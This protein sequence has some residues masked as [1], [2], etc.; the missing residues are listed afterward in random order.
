MRCARRS[1]SESAFP[2]RVVPIPSAGSLRGVP[3]VRPAVLARLGLIAAIGL[4]A[5][6]C[7]P[8][9]GGSE[10]SS[11][12]D[13]TSAPAREE[14]PAFTLPSLEGEHVTLSDFRGKIVIID[15][16]ATWCPPCEFQVPELNAFWA[17]HRDDGDIA[18]FGISVDEGGPEVVRAWV[19]EKGVEYPILLGDSGLA[20]RYGSH[21]LEQACRV[22][23]AADMID[24]YRL[25]KL[26]ELA[27]PPTPP[28][29]SAQVVPISRY[30]RPAQQYALPLTS[31]SKKGDRA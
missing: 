14:A 23:V 8:S 4:V 20:R 6:G 13:G 18:V 3:R 1:R 22:A 28:A 31:R 9:G 30:L 15:F 17:E 21:R 25:R 7:S 16:W 19:E 24:V 2:P 26:L 12:G 5:F 29:S 27:L 10:D 11:G